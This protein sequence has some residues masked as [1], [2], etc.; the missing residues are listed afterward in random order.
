MPYGARRLCRLIACAYID[1][2]RLFR[3]T[4][5]HLKGF[6]I[7]DEH[8]Q[9]TCCARLGHIGM[10]SAQ[11]KALATVGD[12]TTLA[13]VTIQNDENISTECLLVGIGSQIWGFA[14]PQCSHLFTQTVLPNAARIRGITQIIGTQVDLTYASSWIAVYGDRYVALAQVGLSALTSLAFLPRLP[15]WTLCVT[16]V[17]HSWIVRTT[18]SDDEITQT[19]AS[20]WIKVLI[21]IG[22]SDNSVAVYHAT[23]CNGSVHEAPEFAF[24]VECV[25]SRC[26]LYSMDIHVPVVHKQES[27]SIDFEGQ[28]AVR[29][30]TARG[31]ALVAAGTV[32]LDVV[33]WPLKLNMDLP[34]MMEGVLYR[35]KGHQGSIHSIL[36]AS[37]GLTLVSGSD[38]RTLQV[39]DVPA[40]AIFLNG[41]NDHE[42][43]L[44]PRH[45]LFGHTGRIWR[46]CFSEN[47]EN[48]VVSGSEDGTCRV[49]NV[50]K[51]RGD[52]V[53]SINVSNIE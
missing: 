40:E 48:M 1:T 2:S 18:S 7:T 4:L 15:H 43:V 6:F 19:S 44:N 33:I 22:L 23:L 38:D 53:A 50:T 9:L 42:I 21:V 8:A 51:D 46:S 45:V 13:I 17:P 12:A 5:P 35:L 39:W 52:C 3:N 28:H 16:L 14:L 25:D 24:R 41:D 29:T 11:G 10:E 27:V 37:S 49:W 30:V 26:L 36:W 20:S 31:Q 32:F 47:N 34:S